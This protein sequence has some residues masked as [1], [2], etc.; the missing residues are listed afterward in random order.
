MRVR[1]VIAADFRGVLRDFARVSSVLFAVVFAFLARRVASNRS[2]TYSRG[3]E[4]IRFRARA[5]PF[6]NNGDTRYRDRILDI[7][8]T[9]CASFVSVSDRIK[10]E[11]TRD[12][13]ASLIRMC[14]SRDGRTRGS[15]ERRVFA[16]S[17]VLRK[18]T[19]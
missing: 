9:A 3:F 1:F 10:S 17:F 4:R 11:L 8:V 13:V 19:R 16:D 2:V 18:G 6:D 7:F 12:R 14:I 5:H 15:H